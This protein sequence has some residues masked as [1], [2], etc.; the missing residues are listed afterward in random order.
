MYASMTD[1]NQPWPG[2]CAL[3]TVQRA[4]ISQAFLIYVGTY[5]ANT[6][7][8]VRSYHVPTMGAFKQ[9]ILRTHVKARVWGH[10]AHPKQVPLDPLQNG[11]HKD[12]DDSQLN[13]TTTDV[14]PEPKVIIAMVRCHCKRNCTSNRC[15][16]K[17][18]NLPCTDLCMC[19]T[20]C[21]DDEDTY[22]ENR[23]SD[24]ESD[25]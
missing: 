2:L 3:H 20:H 5:F 8:K 4:S 25:D 9:H 12:H 19:N 15:S 23:D 10:A 11:Y 18:N 13:P 7:Q 24:D 14:P 21:E 22:Y 17:S 6:W 1:C 16:C